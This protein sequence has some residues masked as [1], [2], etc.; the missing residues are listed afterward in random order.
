M[1]I[2]SLPQLPADKANHLIYGLAAGLVGAFLARQI[3]YIEPGI[4]AV[5][6]AVILGAA[7]EIVDKVW[8]M[9]EPS[10]ADALATAAGGVVIAAAMVL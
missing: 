3:G 10:I 2:S 4:A 7:K 5:A 8:Q 1:N 9:G 6:L